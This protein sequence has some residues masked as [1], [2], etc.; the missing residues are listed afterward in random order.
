MDK[1]EGKGQGLPVNGSTMHHRHG[2]AAARTIYSWSMLILAQGNVALLPAKYLTLSVQQPCA[3]TRA[4]P[5]PATYG[6]TARQLHASAS[7]RA[8]PRQLHAQ[9]SRLGSTPRPQE[10]R[11]ASRVRLGQT[12]HEPHDKLY[13][14]QLQQL[15]RRAPDCSRNPFDMPLLSLRRVPMPYG[16]MSKV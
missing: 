2:T 5:R 4:L 16:K 10:V 9:P 12:R 6:W 1:T 7:V 11:S 13:C 14:R 3:S 15:H 8:A